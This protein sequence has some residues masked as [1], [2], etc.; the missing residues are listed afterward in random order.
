M[1][2]E[3]V[4]TILQQNYGENIKIA[5][6]PYKYSM[7]DCMESV[8]LAAVDAGLE[9]AIVP[10][11]YQTLPDGE[12]H[13]EREYFFPY[14]TLPFEEVQ[15]GNYDII[16]IHYPY[17][18]CNNVTKLPKSE[19]AETLK[20]YGK[21]CYI[22]Y[23]G[24]IAGEQWSRFYRMP[25]ARDSDIIVLGSM[26]DYEVFKRENP[27]YSGKIITTTGSPKEDAAEI[28]K[29][30]AIPSEWRDLKKPIIVVSGTLW[31]FTHDPYGRMQ[32]HAEIIEKELK[33]GNSVIYRPHPLVFPAIKAMRPEAAS[34]YC[35]FLDM[36]REMGAILDD[37]PDL[38]RTL[39][40]ADFLYTDP[41]SVIKTY[42]PYCKPY[43]VI[44]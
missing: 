34:K 4:I 43:E 35:D 41:S 44:E 10:L 6:C 1:I 8:Y 23:H 42:K 38:H 31:T 15:S 20:Q 14:A 29:N 30:R 7:F 33:K 21:V 17:D 25:G 37:K 2:G 16:V 32:K 18:G 22:P 12:W 40:A 9:T 3:K 11:D 27:N 36:V 19:W 13:N 24:N 5:F 28:H 39:A 26:L